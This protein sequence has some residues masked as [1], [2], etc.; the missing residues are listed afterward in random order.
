V[1]SS[2]AQWGGRARVASPWLHWSQGCQILR[3]GVSSYPH[4]VRGRRVL[5]VA[6]CGLILRWLRPGLLASLHEPAVLWRGVRPYYWLADAWRRHCSVA[7][8]RAA[9]LLP[10]LWPIP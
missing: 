9:A 5:I 7:L 8:R 3:S 6:L 4:V 1:W 2:C 10:C